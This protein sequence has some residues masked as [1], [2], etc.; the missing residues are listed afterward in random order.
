MSKIYDQAR[1]AL[2]CHTHP[3]EA[4]AEIEQLRSALKDIQAK[5]VQFKP[6]RYSW[7]YDRAEVSLAKGDGG[8]MT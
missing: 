3:N 7:F 2:W 5:A 4:A 6:P 8:G 1:L